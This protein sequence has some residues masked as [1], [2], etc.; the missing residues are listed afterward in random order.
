MSQALRQASNMSVESYPRTIAKPVIFFHDRTIAT[1]TTI[2]A[3]RLAY[4]GHLFVVGKF[5]FNLF[6]LNK[7]IIME[8][9]MALTIP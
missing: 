1:T 9:G 8:N 2:A 6:K 4:M 3:D 7:C 5:P